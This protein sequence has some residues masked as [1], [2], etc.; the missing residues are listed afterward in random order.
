MGIK[1]EDFAKNLPPKEMTAGIDWLGI[2]DSFDPAVLEGR[3]TG[4]TEVHGSIPL[5]ATKYLP[6]ND[7]E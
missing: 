2:L 6:L 7:E 1:T 4:G 3:Y 5:P